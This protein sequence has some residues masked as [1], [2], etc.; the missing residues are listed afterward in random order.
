MQ[1]FRD[2]LDD[3]I[4][5]KLYCKVVKVVKWALIF[6]SNQLPIWVV[7]GRVKRFWIQTNNVGRMSC[8]VTFTIN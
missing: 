7:W 5:G 8:V 6:I 2:C 3:K 4:L 1:S